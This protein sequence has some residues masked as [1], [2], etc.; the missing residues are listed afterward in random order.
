MIVQPTLSVYHDDPLAEGDEIVD[1]LDRD[2]SVILSYGVVDHFNPLS[3]PGGLVI[4]EA[5][6]RDVIVVRP[7][8]PIELEDAG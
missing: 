6:L 3:E 2:G 5:V 1:V 4:K 8:P 7:M